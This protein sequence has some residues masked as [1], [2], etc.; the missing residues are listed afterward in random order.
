[1]S[2]AAKKIKYCFNTSTIRGQKLPLAE[3]IDIAARAGYQAIEPWINEI[4]AHQQSGGTLADLKKRISDHGLTVESAIGFAKW[5]VDDDAERAKGVEEMKADMDLVRQIGGLRIAAPPA[6]ATERADLNLFKA[7]DRYRAILELGEKMEVIPQAEL[8]GFSKCMHRLGETMLVAIESG[9]PKACV[10]LD[11][12][13]I[14]KGGSDYDGLKLIAGPAITTLHMNDFPADPPRATITDAH[15]V[16][17]GDGVAPMKQILRDLFSTGFQ[18]AMSLELFN[19][20]YYKED[21]LLVARTG[22]EKMKKCVAEA[23]A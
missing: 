3:V 7:A 6:G 8:W 13:H 1:M 5:V 23:V 16:Y 19:P 20:S 10:V 14:Y 15:R 17:P 11:V 21:P 22:L 2:D 9:H 4:K 18:G 12:Y